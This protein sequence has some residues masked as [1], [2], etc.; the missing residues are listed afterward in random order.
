VP[1]P[2]G[3]IVRGAATVYGPHGPE[4]G[5]IEVAAWGADHCKIT[6]VLGPAMLRRQITAVR[7]GRQANVNGP[8][9]LVAAIPL[10][11]DPRIAP[12][13]A[14]ALLPA[15]A[16]KVQWLEGEKPAELSAAGGALGGATS[17]TET[18]GG[19]LRLE[20]HF[21]TSEN[22]DFTAADFI[23]PPLPKPAAGKGG[24]Q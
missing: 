9:E 5:T 15:G 11:L 10:P 24:G 3:V 22:H 17:L 21:T 23:P 12:G 4:S 1:T 19:E 6:I 20:I 8:S 7:N 2:T 13:T 14:C 18:V 16:G